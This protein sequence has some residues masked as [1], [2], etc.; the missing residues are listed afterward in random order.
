[1]GWQVSYS[2]FIIT[3]IN[4][5]HFKSSCKT[6]TNKY[7]ICY[8]TPQTHSI[9]LRILINQNAY[10]AQ[11]PPNNHP[12]R[13]QDNN[14]HNPLHC[15]PIPEIPHHGPQAHHTCSPRNHHHNH[16]HHQDDA[17]YRCCAPRPR[18]CR[19]CASPQAPCDHGRQGVW[20]THEVEGHLDAQ[21]WCQ[22]CW[23]TKDAWN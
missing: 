3:T 18:D 4:L 23:N 20:C 17:H 8:Q 2:L 1:M 16:H 9:Q 12:R 19:A 6:I 11:D 7:Y 5:P 21:A 10:H 13:P 14:T 15:T 22:G